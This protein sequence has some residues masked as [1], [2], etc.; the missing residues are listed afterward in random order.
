MTELDIFWTRFIEAFNRTLVYGFV[1]ILV[2]C[3]FV[4]FGIV[5]PIIV[6]SNKNR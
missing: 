6:Y 3:L 4:I 5:G 1:H 2:L